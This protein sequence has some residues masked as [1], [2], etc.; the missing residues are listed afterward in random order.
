MLLLASF[1]YTAE[2][3]L[4]SLHFPQNKNKQKFF[5]GPLLAS[6]FAIGEGR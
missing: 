4:L 5:A 6:A 3:R 2:L 1:N